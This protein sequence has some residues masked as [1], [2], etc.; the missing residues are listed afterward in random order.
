MDTDRDRDKKIT[1]PDLRTLHW[2][3]PPSEVY[4]CIYCMIND[5]RFQIENHT[6]S[7]QQ[8]L[9]IHIYEVGLEE[10]RRLF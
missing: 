4:A 6:N 5:A 9:Y 7:K 3:F 1:L 8:F 10:I 2:Y